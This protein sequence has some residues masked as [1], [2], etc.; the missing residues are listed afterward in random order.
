MTIGVPLERLEDTTFNLAG[1]VTGHCDICQGSAHG[2]TAPKVNLAV[3]EYSSIQEDACRNR[4]TGQTNQV[5][6]RILFAIQVD[7]ATQW[8]AGAFCPVSVH[9]KTQVPHIDQGRKTFSSM[10]LQGTQSIF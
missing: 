1:Q 7:E 8:W 2:L 3:T 4:K 9:G 5:A 6:L 10:I